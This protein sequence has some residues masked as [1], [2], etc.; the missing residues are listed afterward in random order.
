MAFSVESI[1]SIFLWQNGFPI[2]VPQPLGTT[3]RDIKSLPV[4]A[5]AM[6]KTLD[7][8]WINPQIALLALYL[9]FSKCF[10]NFMVPVISV[11]PRFVCRASCLNHQKKVFASLW[12][13]SDSPTRMTN[14]KI[15]LCQLISS[16]PF[17]PFSSEN[18]DREEEEDQNTP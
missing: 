11:A 1:R 3:E 16:A 12:A 13:F 2:N 14:M 17:S 9:R 8:R 5:E 18:G 6:I 10:G 7:L 15:V 4:P